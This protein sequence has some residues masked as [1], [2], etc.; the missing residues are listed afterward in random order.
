MPDL[1]ACH[2]AGSTVIV[3]FFIFIGSLWNRE[4]QTDVLARFCVDIA[5]IDRGGTFL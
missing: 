4:I 5:T 3:N 1:V 2:F